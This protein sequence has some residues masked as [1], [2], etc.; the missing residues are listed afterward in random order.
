MWGRGRN[1]QYYGRIGKTFFDVD[2]ATLGRWVGVRARFADRKVFDGDLRVHQMARHDDV[3]RPVW[4]YVLT[5]HLVAKPAWCVA[6]DSCSPFGCLDHPRPHAI[7]FVSVSV[8]TSLVETI[9]VEV[10][11]DMGTKELGKKEL[12]MT[13]FLGFAEGTRSDADSLRLV[14]FA[15]S[16]SSRPTL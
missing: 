7:A 1:V 15:F 14:S 5:T 4:E 2:A 12:G 13:S 10:V 16:F 3:V 11:H 9:S 8:E 6:C